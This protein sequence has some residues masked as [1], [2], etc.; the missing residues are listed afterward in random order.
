MDSD[1]HHPV[2]MSPARP[3]GAFIIHTVVNPVITTSSRSTATVSAE[4]ITAFLAGL[5]V[6]I[7]AA[8]LISEDK[9]HTG[10]RPQ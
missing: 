5:V 6:G 1:L 9:E 2:I 8:N 4:A 3:P 7:L 10:S